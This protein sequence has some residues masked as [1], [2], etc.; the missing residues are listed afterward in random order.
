MYDKKLI[1]FT[2]EIYCKCWKWKGEKRGGGYVDRSPFSFFYDGTK[3]AISETHSF[4][5]QSLS[6]YLAF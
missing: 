6:Y 5:L 2:L 4:S 1:K 3:V